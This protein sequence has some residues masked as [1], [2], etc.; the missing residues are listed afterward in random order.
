MSANFIPRMGGEKKHSIHEYEIK[1]SDG[2]T[3]GKSMHESK[4]RTSDQ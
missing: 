2:L 3:E 1:T 4:V